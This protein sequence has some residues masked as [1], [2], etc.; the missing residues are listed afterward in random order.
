[1][2]ITTKGL[3]SWVGITSLR[4]KRER[5]WPGSCT[6]ANDEE[7][8]MG[9]VRPLVLA[10]GLVAAALGGCSRKN[11]GDG[12]VRIDCVRRAIVIARFAAS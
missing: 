3:S 12:E 6:M 1:M 9:R 10:A 2:D 7:A 11:S 5:A 4:P 8:L